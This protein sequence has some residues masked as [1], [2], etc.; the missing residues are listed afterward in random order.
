MPRV[1]DAN[2]SRH[3]T[4]RSLKVTKVSEIVPDLERLAFPVERLTPLQGLLRLGR[5]LRR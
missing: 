3:N 1:A 4:G 5:D 2:R